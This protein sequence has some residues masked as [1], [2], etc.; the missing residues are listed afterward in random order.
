LQVAELNLARF[1]EDLVVPPKMIDTIVDGEVV[2]F[3]QTVDNQ[4]IIDA[5]IIYLSWHIH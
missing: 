4:S 3:L 1:I 2:F 5:I